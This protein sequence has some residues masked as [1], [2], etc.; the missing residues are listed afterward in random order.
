MLLKRRLSG[1]WSE[2]LVTHCSC[3]KNLYQFDRSRK[4]LLLGISL[5]GISMFYNFEKIFYTFIKILSCANGIIIIKHFLLQCMSLFS[6][7][8]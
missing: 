1:I 6:A 8:S 3:H 5:F 7:F 4:G 2:N